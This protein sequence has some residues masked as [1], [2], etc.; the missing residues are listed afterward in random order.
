MVCR[1]VVLFLAVPLAIPRS[2]GA[3][4]P[5]T[6]PSPHISQPANQ[7]GGQVSV[8]L[9]TSPD[10][11]YDPHWVIEVR[12]FEFFTPGLSFAAYAGP[13]ITTETACKS[14]G[15]FH[16]HWYF[17]DDTGCW[18]RGPTTVQSGIWKPA[19]SPNQSYCETAIFGN[20]A[21]SLQGQ[22]T[23]YS[24]IRVLVSAIREFSF[25][26]IKFKIKRRVQ[27]GVVAF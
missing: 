13:K 1:Y 24:K 5:Q 9:A 2:A 14:I 17:N 18:G 23:H 10:T 25:L 22:P 12:D 7:S 11:S 19:I 21:T 16:Q 4:C 20:I 26:G 8:T 27:A 3:D 15:V 6:P